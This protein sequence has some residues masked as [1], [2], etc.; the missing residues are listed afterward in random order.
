MKLWGE[1]LDYGFGI[2]HLF[3]SPPNEFA[4]QLLTSADQR[5]NAT[6]TLLTMDRPNASSLESSRMATEMFLK[7]YLA[8]ISRLTEAEAKRDIGHNLEEA[9]NRCL[10]ANPQSELDALRKDL[11]VF[12]DVGNRYRGADPPLGILWKAYEVAQFTGATVCRSLTG[13]D[14]EHR[15]ASAG[16]VIVGVSRSL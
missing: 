9:L 11:L 13:R 12:P 10:S 4:E 8:A 16:F 7:A 14:S 2:D 3:S 5:L 6:A 15:C 1:C